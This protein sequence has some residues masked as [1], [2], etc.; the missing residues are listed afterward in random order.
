MIAENLL[1]VKN[2]LPQDVQLVA[3][4]KYHP[5]SEVM[6]A[7]GV[8]QRIFGEN[9]VQELRLKQQ[10]L[11]RD[12]EWHFI[13]HLQK[14]KVKYIAPYVALIHSVDTLELLEEINRQALKNG[15]VI[16]C[17]LQIH[18]AREETKFGLTKD[19]C[20]ALLSSGTW[21]DMA[22]IRLRGL[23]CMASNVDNEQQVAGEFDEVNT[24]W[25]EIKNRYF[26]D[27]E[28]FNLRSWGM[29]H[30]YQIAVRHGSNMVRV[31]TYIFGPR[32]VKK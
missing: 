26:A 17:L 8:G 31:G 15:R 20:R 1:K 10:D 23:M 25:H 13:G 9:I 24:L 32:P 12:I 2:E 16:P 28:A 4:S 11:P 5:E 21:R 30:D 19:E 14:N 6:E 29:S 27:D 22:G 3:V 7:Y 18:I